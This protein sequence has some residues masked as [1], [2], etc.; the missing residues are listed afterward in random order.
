MTKRLSS[1]PRTGIAFIVSAPA[2]AGK[3]TLVNMLVKEF[4]C[5]EESTSCTTRSPRA[6][7]VDG[8]DYFFIDKEEFQ[9]R[10]A[11]EDFL[12][13]AEVFGFKYGTSKEQLQKK[14]DQGRHVFLVIDTQ[15][16]MQL[17]Q[18][19]FKAV[20]IFIAPPS[21]AALEERLI[22]RQTEDEASRNT[23]LSWAKQELAVSKE[24]DYLIV[25]DDL[26]TAY[27][28][29]KRIVIAEENKLT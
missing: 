3:T 6:H 10:V 25:N 22:K 12:E 2:G 8:K 13:H 29:L 15:G 27:S 5:I 14:L 7:E 17:K 9:R 4:S 1:N 28:E 24:Y 11:Q 16:A 20:Y 21:I 26:N 23:R 19:G 18:K